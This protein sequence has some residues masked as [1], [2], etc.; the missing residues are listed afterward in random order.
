M[1]RKSPVLA[2]CHKGLLLSWVKF[3]NLDSTTQQKLPFYDKE[4]YQERLDHEEHQCSAE[5]SRER[6][7]VHKEYEQKLRQQEAFHREQIQ[8]QQLFVEDLKQQILSGQIKAERELE[9]DQALINQQIRENQQWLIKEHNQLAALQQQQ[10]EFGVQT[11]SKS[12]AEAEVQNTVELE[13][14]PSLVEQNQKRLV[15]LELLQKYSLKKA[16]RNIR[17]K[18]VK[19]QL[20]KIVKKQ[21][22]L[23][24]KRKLEQL[25]A[26]CWLSEDNL[27]QTQTLNQNAAVTPWHHELQRRSKSL[28]SSSLPQI[29]CLF[30]NCHP[31]HIRNSLLK[32]ETTSKSS[33]LSTSPNT[34]QCP[35]CNPPGKSL[36]VNYLPRTAKG[37]SGRDESYSWFPGHRQLT[38]KLKTS[39]FG[40]KKGVEKDCGSSVSIAHVSKEMKKSDDSTGQ[41]EYQSQASPTCSP[42]HFRKEGEPETFITGTRVTKSKASG[43]STQPAEKHLELKDTQI[44]NK[45]TRMDLTGKHQD[46]LLEGFTKEMKKSVMG[47][48]PSS[49]HLSQTAK[50]LKREPKA[51]LLSYNKQPVEQQEFLMAA[52]SVGNL[53]KMNTQTPLHYIEK[54]WHSAEMLSTGVSKAVT[55]MLGN[56]QEDGENEFSD[57]DSSYSVDSLSCAYAKALTEQLKQEDSDRNK[58]I[59]NPE[60]SESDDSQMSQDSLA[61]KESK[62]KKQN[63]SRFY[64]L[65]VHQE[66]IKFFKGRNEQRVSPLVTSCMSRRRLAKAE[67]SFSLDSL[68][69]AEE[70]LMEDLVEE[71]KSDSSDEMPAEIFWRLQSPRAPTIQPEELHKPEACSKDMK[72]TNY[73]PN[74]SSSFYLDTKIQSLS[75]NAYTRQLKE[76][77]VS[78]VE[79][80]GALHQKFYSTGGNPLFLNNTWSSYDSKSEN[81]SA[82]IAVSSSHEHLEFQD[83]YLCSSS[84]PEQWTKKDELKQSAAEVS[85]V[86]GYKQLHRISNLSLSINKINSIFTSGASEIPL[87]ETAIHHQLAVSQVPE[88]GTLLNKTLK[89]NAK[90]KESSVSESSDMKSS[91][92]S[93]VGRNASFVPISASSAKHSYCEVARASDPKHEELSEPS[94]YGPSVECIQTSSCSKKASTVGILSHV[95][96]KEEDTV[97]T[98]Y[99]ELSKDPVFKEKTLVSAPFV[100]VPQP[101]KGPIHGE[102]EDSFFRTIEKTDTDY[103]CESSI[104]ESEAIDSN[105]G[106]AFVSVGISGFSRDLALPVLGTSAVKQGVV[107]NHDQLFARKETSTSCDKNLF[108][109]NSINKN[110]NHALK[111]SYTL[112]TPVEQKE[113]AS[114]VGGTNSVLTQK[115]DY[116]EI[117]AEEITVDK[118]FSSGKKPYQTD[119]ATF[120]QDTSYDQSATPIQTS[121]EETICTKTSREILTEMALETTSFRHTEDCEEKDEKLCSLDHR[122]FENKIDLM[123]DFHECLRADNPECC[124]PRYTRGNSMIC[125]KNRRDKSNENKE[126]NF[127]SLSLGQ[128]DEL[129]Y[130]NVNFKGRNT[131]FSTAKTYDIRGASTVQSNSGAFGHSTTKSNLFQSVFESEKYNEQCQGFT[132]V[133]ESWNS[134]SNLNIEPNVKQSCSGINSNCSCPKCY[135]QCQEQKNKVQKEAEISL[136]FDVDIFSDMQIQNKSLCESKNEKEAAFFCKDPSESNCSGEVLFFGGTNNYMKTDAREVYEYNTTRSASAFEEGSPYSNKES[137]CLKKEVTAEIQVIPEETTVPHQSKKINKNEDI[138]KLIDSV[139]KP[140]GSILD[141]KSRQSEKLSNYSVVETQHDIADRSFNLES[142][143]LDERPKDPSELV[144]CKDHYEM[145]K[146]L[147]TPVLHKE[148]EKASSGVTVAEVGYSHELEAGV[149][150]ASC[151]Q[152]STFHQTQRKEN[153]EISIL[154]PDTDVSEITSSPES[155]SLTNLTQNTIDFLDANEDLMRI[156]RMIENVL[157]TDKIATAKQTEGSQEKSLEDDGKEQKIISSNKREV[158]TAGCL[159]LA[160]E[161]FSQENKV[162][163]SKINSEVTEGEEQVNVKVNEGFISR[164]RGELH[165]GKNIA[166]FTEETPSLAQKY[167]N[168]EIINEYEIPEIYL[169]ASRPEEHDPFT[170]DNSDGTEI[171]K[172][173]GL[174][175]LWISMG[176]MN[177]LMKDVDECDSSADDSAL[178]EQHKSREESKGLVIKE[179]SNTLT[180][181][182]TEYPE[183]DASENL[184]ADTVGS[185]SDIVYTDPVHSVVHEKEKAHLI[186]LV[187]EA[188]I[189]VLKENVKSCKAP[190]FR[191]DRERKTFTDNT[192][193]LELTTAQNQNELSPEDKGNCYLS[194]DD[195]KL[196]KIL[197]ESQLLFKDFAR[198][199]DTSGSSVPS[200]QQSIPATDK[201]SEEIQQCSLE[202][203]PCPSV[204]DLLYLGINNSAECAQVDPT[205]LKENA[206]PVYSNAGSGVILP[207]Y[208][209]L[210]GSDMHDETPSTPNRECIDESFS[211]KM[212]DEEGVFQQTMLM[213]ERQRKLFALKSISN[214]AAPGQFGKDDMHSTAYTSDCRNS[215]AGAVGQDV[216]RNSFFLGRLD[217]SE[218]IIQNVSN[219]CGVHR[220]GLSVCKQSKDYVYFSENA[221]QEGKDVVE[222]RLVVDSPS[223]ENSNLLISTVLKDQGEKMKQHLPE[224]FLQATS[225][226]INLSRKELHPLAQ[227]DQTQESPVANCIKTGCKGLCERFPDVLTYQTEHSEIQAYKTPIELCVGYPDISAFASENALTLLER[228]IQ[229]PWKTAACAEDSP[230][231]NINSYNSKTSTSLLN[232]PDLIETIEDKIDA[233]CFEKAKYF[234][235]ESADLG[236]PLCFSDD[237]ATSQKEDEGKHCSTRRENT[238]M[239]HVELSQEVVGTDQVEKQNKDSFLNC[240]DKE[241][242]MK[243]SQS[244]DSGSSSSM[245]VPEINCLKYQSLEQM[246]SKETKPLPFCSVEDFSTCTVY[247][248]YNSLSTFDTSSS[249][250]DSKPLM[251]NQLEDSLQDTYL[252]DQLSSTA[253]EPHSVQ[254]GRERAFLQGFPK[255]CYSSL[256]MFSECPLTSDIGYNE[257]S[258]SD[259]SHTAT[260]NCSKFAKIQMQESQSDD[261]VVFDQ[262]SSTSGN[263]MYSLAKENRHVPM[264]HTE[265]TSDADP[266]ADRKS[267]NKNNSKPNNVQEHWDKIPPQKS[268]ENLEKIHNE[269]ISMPSL[270]PFWDTARATLNREANVRQT[271]SRN[272]RELHSNTEK[273]VPVTERKQRKIFLRKDHMENQTRA[274]SISANDFVDPQITASKNLSLGDADADSMYICNLYW[275]VCP[276]D[277]EDAYTDLQDNWQPVRASEDDQGR[278]NINGG[279]DLIHSKNNTSSSFESHTDNTDYNPPVANETL[280]SERLKLS[281]MNSENTSFGVLPEDNCLPPQESPLMLLRSKKSCFATQNTKTNKQEEQKSCLHH[282]LSAPAIAVISDLEYSPETSAKTDLSLYPASKSL[283]ELNMSVEPPSPTDDDLHGIER[284]SKQASDNLMQAKYKTRFQQRSVQTKRFANYDPKNLQ[285]CGERTQRSHSRVPSLVHCPPALAHIS[286]NSIDTNANNTSVAQCSEGEELREQSEETDLFLPDNKDAM[287]FSSSDINPYIHPWQQDGPGKIGWKQYVF[288]SASDVSCNQPP[289]TLDNHKVMRCSSVDNGLNSHNSPFH[290]HLSSYA[291]AKVLSSTLSSAEDLQGW[292][293]MRRDF[294]STYSSDSTKHYGNAS[295][296]TLETN[297]ENRIMKLNNPSEQPVNTSMQVDEI[298]LLYPSESEIASKKSQGSTCEQGTQTVGAGR[299]KRHRRHRRSYTDVS[300]KKQET[301]LFPQPSWGSMQN[302][303]MHLSQLLQNTSELLGNLS[304]HNIIDSKQEAKSKGRLIDVDTVRATVLD[305]YTQTTADIGIQTDISEYLR[306][307]YEENLI[308]AKKGIELT[309]SQ[310]VNV[311]GKGVSSEAVKKS[312]KK[313]DVILALQGRTRGSNE[314][315]RQS[316]PDF[317]EST[318]DVWEDSFMHLPMLAR[319]STPILD[320]L[321]PPLNA[322]QSV[323]SGSTRVSS[324]ASTLPS[325][326]HDESSYTV[327]SSPG[328]S[329]FQ[330]TTCYTQEKRGADELDTTAERKLCYK[331]NF[332]VDR[333]SSPILTLSASPNSQITCSKSVCSIKGSVEHPND[334]SGFLI[335]QRKHG[336]R[337]SG[338]EPHIDNFSQTE[339]DSESSPSR[340]NKKL[341]KK[342]GNFSNTTKEILGINVSKDSREKHRYAVDKRTTI[343]AKRLYNSSSTLEVSG[344]GEPLV[345]REHIPMKHSLHY[346][347]IT[348]RGR[349]SFGGIGYGKNTGDA[350]ISL[351]KDCSQTSC[352]DECRHSSPNSDLLFNQEVSTHWSSKTNVDES[353]QHQAEASSP[354]FHNSYWKNQN[355]CSFPLSDMSDMQI[356]FQDDDTASITTSECNT[357]ILLNE[358]TSLVKTHRPR[359]YSLRDLPMHNKFSNW[360]GVKGSPSSSLISSSGS[361]A[362]LQNQVEKNLISKQAAEIQGKSQL[363]ESRA[364]EIERLQKERAQIMSGIHLDLNQH[365]LTVELTEAKLNYGI[366]ETDAML[367]ILQ[368]GTGEDLTLIPIKQQLYERHMRTIE[369]LR[370]DRAERLQSYRRSRSLSPQKHVGLLQTLDTSQ[371]DLDLPSRRREYLQQLRR[372]VVQNTRVQQPKRRTV[373]HPSEIELLLQDYQR[374]REEAK[375]EIARA[376][377][378]LRERAEQEKRRIREQ[379]F[380]QLQKEEAKLKTLLST[381][382]LCTD[383]SLSLSSGPT[384]GYNSSNTATYTASKFS[385]WEGQ[386]PPGS[387]DL[388][389]GDTR[390]RSAVRNSQLYVLEQLQK[391]SACG[392]SRVQSSPSSSSIS[393]RFTHG[394]TISVSSSSTKGYQDL[395]KHILTNAIT[396]VMAAC[397]NNLRNFYNRQAAAGWK[398]QCIEKEVLV[399]Y[400]VFPSATKHGFLGAGVIERPLPSV[401]CIVKDPGKRY[402]YDKTITTVRVHKKVTSHIQLVYLVSDTSLCYLKQ[403]RDFC[404]ITIEAKEEN[405]SIL[406]IQSVYDE[407][408]P[409]PCKEVVRGEILP[410]AW[411]LEPDILDGK[412]ITRVIYMTQ[413][414]LGAP[415]IPARL[416]SSIA[417]RQ[418]LVIARLAHFLAS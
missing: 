294:E 137:E 161:N 252:A 220:M 361:A 53:N 148:P 43:S 291:T 214:C 8:R 381:S 415:A 329:N 180:S 248:S 16:E 271:L 170:V 31:P 242:N 37:I 1:V 183:N 353:S 75:K 384:S 129:R 316:V 330:S 362:D 59:T 373:Q 90:S 3:I 126:H 336:P 231:Y 22:L 52:T 351:I 13:I 191:T 290:S 375:T 274:S 331:N 89:E 235:S 226:D 225:D 379:I 337:P 398:Y 255:A 122:E 208:E 106:G 246:S 133:N 201:S 347:Y 210:M 135:L 127:I 232:S 412:D 81:N 69:D 87:P 5:V 222:S 266:S 165:A 356:P 320:F 204:N 61:E 324:V 308:K 234:K 299:Y 335:N 366:G 86:S 407:S 58:C 162:D 142:S 243:S 269:N 27:K 302:L 56:W 343:Q 51:S 273:E 287:H 144:V 172:N 20:E 267:V 369:A 193:E 404:C 371:R 196:N 153:M 364:R 202:V 301:S 97:P 365:P 30:C 185:S 326:G 275:P 390:G 10:R 6:D 281:G 25:E 325:S 285:N 184:D 146:E 372:D 389:R 344:H 257:T 19:F 254:K 216:K 268:L 139:V 327:V 136:G 328:S 256:K 174:P 238:D 190:V 168:E 2:D 277:N 35:E 342:S 23:E 357:E 236:V 46:S 348:R 313:K 279:K 212:Q 311:I 402:L 307:K 332:L 383:S 80:E 186:N 319:A 305:S 150:S 278:P 227:C 39:S 363:S 92:V 354:Q 258:R 119:P 380:S 24:A 322:Q 72:E 195:S 49:G 399:Y 44:F 297:P 159:M 200:D 110:G 401:W 205:V 111:E 32:K 101:R 21:K 158:C 7:S 244:E 130:L 318:D 131:E 385:K 33:E 91:F 410:S 187:M 215:V 77:E 262:Q 333:A 143:S 368:N 241:E 171:K 298:V 198:N 418:P 408:M 261:S 388:S 403:P 15:Q 45:K 276:T 34:C 280:K 151:L 177:T 396:E 28:G 209:T 355:T 264:S 95:H 11:E 229:P 140:E 152:T 157:S 315:R 292:D 230:R 223:S 370:K 286:D 102:L 154:L 203:F 99:A 367:R 217:S 85:F 55:D 114:K 288:G 123:N 112:Q 141:M 74:L 245:K 416:L 409:R 323:A 303:S 249:A 70:V 289:L 62:A 293:D 272:E 300:A 128:E 306:S 47:G 120:L 304:Q 18:K 400:K 251:F 197:K 345:D 260:L 100:H 259:D 105:A 282:R 38:K 173:S 188:K 417:K 228:S 219:S 395:S 310:E 376:R 138:A 71:S 156:N 194:N 321:K 117:S 66:P 253:A 352:I 240:H 284:F 113:S 169:I 192:E 63:K 163:G 83:S 358:N 78:F 41:T 182:C 84:K 199:N 149:G 96:G 360:C 314:S 405:L 65:K 103:S 94:M 296:E 12:Y 250:E 382:T 213:E 14:C 121:P 377:D 334:A 391:D 283:Q 392:S 179:N 406:A 60:D 414:D 394:L 115:V 341:S 239:Q 166:L 263:I 160:R 167:H 76:V 386:I 79:E 207:Y 124:L 211:D 224:A 26:S 178:T 346:M 48:K 218:T 317:S 237:L 309:K 17:R 393:C 57:T 98:T 247:P 118:G 50:N 189:D 68:A 175:D 359:S 374:A 125:A 411:I 104:A 73:E 270:S 42:D 107:E 349:G 413:V 108:L 64:K 36:S 4:D 181:S 9:N 206:K 176:I 155:S 109:S 397:S 93:S 116:K 221:A 340:D 29:R 145:Y 378:K 82:R 350:D 88:S 233:V 67:R 312:P 295:S 387:A 147:H 40:N 54:K 132:T 265:A 134:A 339:A 164:R 338:S